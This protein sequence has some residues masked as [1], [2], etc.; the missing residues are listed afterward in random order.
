MPK[1]V[2]D[3]A[4]ERLY[5]TGVDRGVLY[6]MSALGAYEAGV[7]WNGLSSISESPSGAEATPVYA[8]NIKYLNLMSAEEFGATL[9]AYTYPKEFA[10]CEGSV[11]PVEGLIIGQQERRAF[12]L[13]F[14]TLIGNDVAGN[15]LGYKLHLIYGAKAAPSEKQYSSINDSPEPLTFSWELTTT[16]VEIEGMKPAAALIIDST[17]L[18]PEKLEALETLLYGAEAT[19]AALPSPAAVIALLTAAG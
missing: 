4:G 5:E 18:A 9:E 3:A 6:P 8:D 14:R 13:C 17:L 7:V 2:W 15:S 16:P 1:L 11:S 12:G 10:V 19:A